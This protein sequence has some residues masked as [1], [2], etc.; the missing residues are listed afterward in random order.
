MQLFTF[1]WYIKDQQSAIEVPQQT[2][3]L[4]KKMLNQEKH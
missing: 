3:S 1:L 4:P 2:G